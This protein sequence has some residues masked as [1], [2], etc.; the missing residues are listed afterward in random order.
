[1]A[2]YGSPCACTCA[3]PRVT[4]VFPK[5]FANL[6]D[7][8]SKG[9]PFRRLFS[10]FFFS[11]ATSSTLGRDSWSWR[12]RLF[13]GTSRRA[14]EGE[15]LIRRAF[16]LIWASALDQTAGGSSATWEGTGEPAE[17]S[18]YIAR[19]S[20]NDECIYT[21]HSPPTL[22]GDKQDRQDRPRRSRPRNLFTERSDERSGLPLS[23]CPFS[24]RLSLSLV[25][26]VKIDHH[27]ERAKIPN[28]ACFFASYKTTTPREEENSVAETKRFLREIFPVL[29]S[30]IILS[31]IL[32]RTSCDRMQPMNRSQWQ[33]NRFTSSS[34]PSDSWR[35]EE[36]QSMY[37]L[38]F[39][40]IEHDRTIRHLLND[41]L[42]NVSS[43]QFVVNFASGR[44]LGKP[45]YLI[46]SRFWTK[47]KRKT[48]SRMFLINLNELVIAPVR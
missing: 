17:S 12:W 4:G 31:V 33:R 1:M 29:F 27:L 45:E 13:Q 32:S 19:D 7:A 6:R 30:V 43:S 14:R 18:R 35:K 5:A 39:F 26:F 28:C 37:E 25:F 41:F 47:G 9:R 21:S 16:P 3:L 2:I 11:Q 10:F 24:L 42:N 34:F 20:L 23:S 46:I 38:S 22:F 8:R 48:I 36:I 15:G 44:Y 40:S